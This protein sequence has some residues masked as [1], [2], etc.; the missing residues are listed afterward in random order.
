MDDA[1]VVHLQFDSDLMLYHYTGV[2]PVG[3]AEFVS[4]ASRGEDF[5][6]HYRGVWLTFTRGGLWPRGLDDELWR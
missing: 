5:N 2:N 3:W 6:A 1:G 4:A